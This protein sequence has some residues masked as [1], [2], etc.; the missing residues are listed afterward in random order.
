MNREFLKKLKQKLQVGNTRSI[1]LNSYPGRL[2][3]R[4]DLF[5]LN[6]VKQNYAGEFIKK[7]L[8]SSSFSFKL[9]LD[10]NYLPQSNEKSKGEP[11]PEHRENISREIPVCQIDIDV[12]KQKINVLNKRLTSLYYDYEDNY[13][14]HGIRSFGFGFPTL[15]YRPKNDPDKILSAPV[16]IW[17]LD[18]TR[19]KNEWI[20]SRDEEQ[21][22][23]I[24]DVLLN[25][26]E[27]DLETSGFVKINDEILSD[28]LVD[29]KEL[30]S[31][32]NLLLT[33]INSASSEYSLPDVISP[34]LDKVNR[35]VSLRSGHN[36][37]IINSGVFG[38][39]KSPKEPLINDI[40]QLISRSEKEEIG[41]SFPEQYQHV[42]YSAVE[43]DPAQE[44]ALKN[45]K[46][47][48]KLIIHGPPGTGKSQTLTAI[49]VNALYNNA[50]CLV[51]CEKRTALEVIQ[52]NL[53][54]LALGSLCALI[55]DVNR[56]R[57]KIVDAVREP[58]E[59]V[60]TVDKNVIESLFNES[61]NAVNEINTNHSFYGK[62]LLNDNTWSDLAGRFLEFGNN[63]DDYLKLYNALSN[64]GIDFTSGQVSG[65][66]NTVINEIAKN[67][68]LFKTAKD[69]LEKFKILNDN[70]FINRSAKEVVLELNSKLSDISHKLEAVV[71]ILNEVNGQYSAA[72][73]ICYERFYNNL[74]GDLNLI[75]ESFN[76]NTAI[77]RDLF[78]N[79]AGFTGFKLGLL[80][81][82]SGKYK[83]LK[84]DKKKIFEQSD[85]LKNYH[86]FGYLNFEKANLLNTPE[87]IYQYALEL[88][89]QL[90]LWYN[91][92]STY[93][94][95][96]V[97]KYHSGKFDIN[98]Y[99]NKNSLLDAEIEA[100][101]MPELL[102]NSAL[103]S[104]K[105]SFSNESIYD[106]H[107]LL[108]KLKQTIDVII[109]DSDCL[110]DYFYW[111]ADYLASGEFTRK[112]ID[113]LIRSGNQNW[114]SNTEQYF[115]FSLL[116]ANE[117]YIKLRDDSFYET[118]SL[119]YGKIK[120]Y[121]VNLIKDQWYTKQKVSAD[122]F[123]ERTGININAL[124]NKSR[125]NKF[126]KRN[127]LRKIIAADFG[128]FTDHFPVML[129]NPVVCSSLFEMKEGLFDLVVFDESSQLRVE[130]VYAAKLRG[131]FRVVSG[132]ENQMPP[133]SYFASSQVLIESDTANEDESDTPP[134]IDPG[135]LADS[136]SL[137]EF[138]S[139]RGYAESFLEI[140]YRSKHPDLIGFSNS[141]FYSNRL[142]P[143]PP[144]VNYKAIR[145]FNVYGIY[146]QAEGVNK[147][148][149]EKVINI[150]KELVDPAKGENNPSIGVATLNVF[151]RN[152]ILDMINNAANNDNSFAAKINIL[153]NK[154]GEP[155]FVK[156]LENIQG[157]ERDVIII[158][159]TFG[160]KAD[161]SFLQN[162]GPVNQE[163]GYRLLNV[164]IT[165]AKHMLIVCTSIPEEYINEYPSMIT[166]SG[167]R[168]KGIF[169]AYLAYA[170]AVEINDTVT[171]TAILSLVAG[172][173]ESEIRR[174]VVNRNSMFEN[175]L[176]KRL[177]MHY[178]EERIIK[179]YTTGGFVI[180]IAV[181]PAEKDGKI[182]A[183][184][185][186]GNN[187]HNSAQAYA[188]DI[189]REKY[190]QRFGMKFIRVWS[191]NWW[192]NESRELE[193][194]IKFINEDK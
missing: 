170:K 143:M 140:H 148:E 106:K 136:E 80:S 93:H 25:Y 39:F 32:I 54:M 90:D 175:L 61:D 114:V 15:V 33:Q 85:I 107:E 83:A 138:A 176:Y 82:F 177:L 65:L 163:K 78:C 159:T 31:I 164:I 186:D 153:R 70:L 6:S 72:L 13:L 128:L 56:D 46:D 43:T 67:R 95:A 35:E 130:D 117:K 71:K 146:N 124:Y 184:E 45:L 41:R 188:W 173:N 179:N 190:L 135:S 55:E 42:Q 113:E 20:I 24:N 108:V 155:F 151:Q 7:L 50:K 76:R 81:L 120:D 150:I 180:D 94:N 121:Q 64:H 17:M 68:K 9:K 165:R 4:L 144:A 29:E 134:V 3:S 44:R 100:G 103:F 58:K 115:I 192:N 60:K 91:D 14:E 145:Y 19:D 16:F 116:V 104:S 79:T 73:K 137:L 132:D 74:S 126:Q 49:I 102:N 152:Y 181:L 97:R 34:M 169:Y 92:I 98:A 38:L 157:D 69:D 191:A 111:R 59:E 86:K 174:S 119:N 129:V 187:D 171:K 22:I 26:L 57:K 84:N 27:Q 141:A 131:K 36:P 158:S 1:H 37:H 47:K 154:P 105:L 178:P 147:Q 51:V 40:K 185:C 142:N 139:R 10:E 77:N 12:R 110:Y 87:L 48:D 62:F 156:N 75:I 172:S 5:D 193:R 118:I 183:I 18:I 99:S 166:A 189:F 149:A 30:T 8:T 194:L 53:D 168:G 161:G 125:N 63:N 88:Q 28:S 23:T 101:K 52:K 2:A 112:I 127:S 122:K 96:E 133:S 162:F 160:K 109:K 21:S 89:A 123:E 11:S 167:N 66:F 182:T